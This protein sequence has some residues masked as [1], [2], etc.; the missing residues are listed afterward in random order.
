MTELALHH[1]FIEA[2]IHKQAFDICGTL[3]E[4]GT[5]YIQVLPVMSGA[6]YYAPA[7]M[8]ELKKTQPGLHIRVIK[9]RTELD[10]F[11]KLLIVDTIYDTGRTMTELLLEYLAGGAF[12]SFAFLIR[13]S[14]APPTMYKTWVGYQIQDKFVYGY[15]L[16]DQDGMNREL[17]D[18]VYH[19]YDFE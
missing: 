16:D 19:D 9:D 12:P 15:G 2:L 8:T 18:I 13:K 6:M 17:P 10:R 1:N 3:R 11:Q 7:L 14:L 5:N 4:W